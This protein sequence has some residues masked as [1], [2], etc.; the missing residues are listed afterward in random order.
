MT[1]HYRHSK[2]ITQQKGKLL[3]SLENFLPFQITLELDNHEQLFN[4]VPVWFFKQ[5]KENILQVLLNA[6]GETL[7]YNYKKSISLV[8]RKSK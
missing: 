4:I 6:S 8:S 3:L 2:L 1:Y 5:S 7:L